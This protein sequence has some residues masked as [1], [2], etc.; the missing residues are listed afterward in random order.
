MA[1]LVTAPPPASRFIRRTPRQHDIRRAYDLWS[2]RYDAF[3]GCADAR[4]RRMALASVRGQRILDVGVGTGTSFAD[5]ARTVDPDALVCGVELT[6][7]ML[8]KA[9]ARLR[10]IPRRGRL[11]AAGGLRLPFRTASFDL[12]TSSY[13]L[14][15]LSE[16]DIG[17]AIEEF[18]RVLEPGGRL[19]LVNLT[20]MDARRITLYERCYR[21]LPGLAQAWLLGGCRPVQVQPLLAAA[22]FVAARRF[23]VEQFLSSEVVIAEKPATRDDR[24]CA[25]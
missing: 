5:L 7:R 13:L 10:A 16:D 25:A 22:G 15:L 17:R 14:D 9:S 23:V 2:Y 20:K 24:P 19:I 1:A 4:A 8:R 3:A 11:L 12:V 18:Y 21:A 6:P